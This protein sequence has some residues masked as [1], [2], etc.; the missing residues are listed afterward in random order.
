[1]LLLTYLLMSL[2]VLSQKAA[3]FILVNRKTNLPI[4]FATVKLLHTKSG[5]YS[6]EKGI[7]NLVC[8]ATDTLLITSVEFVP[9]TVA[10]S[11]IANDTVFLEPRIRQLDPVMAKHKKLIG[12]IEFGIKGIRDLSWGA[13]GMGEEFAQ[14]FLLP[15]DTSTV[16]KLKRVSIPSKGFNPT[17]PAVLHVYSVNANTG[18]PGEEL[19]QNRY[20]IT[21]QNFKNKNF[22]IDLDAENLFIH[23]KNIFVSCEFLGSTESKI[24]KSGFPTTVYMTYSMPEVFTFS[25]SLLQ[26]RYSWFPFKTSQGGKGSL[27]PANTMFSIEVEQYKLETKTREKAY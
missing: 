22:I 10:L 8:N 9:F 26:P 14:L 17:S 19:L 11:N 18:L 5:S 25:R 15:A 6:D 1:M 27:I 21:K 2:T 24:T 7:F 4:P 20:F 13:S 16:F 12:K 3:S 23:E